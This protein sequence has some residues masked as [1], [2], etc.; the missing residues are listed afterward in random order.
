MFECKIDEQ[1]KTLLTY[2]RFFQGF[3]SEYA[4]SVEH[5]QNLIFFYSLHLKT[6]KQMKNFMIKFMVT[7]AVM[8]GTFCVTYFGLT[9]VANPNDE[10]GIAIF[11]CILSFAA[12]LVVNAFM[13]NLQSN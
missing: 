13:S 11:G 4:A 1:P 2:S 5:Q 12:M 8:L 3:V 10:F 9:A 6:F 7:Y